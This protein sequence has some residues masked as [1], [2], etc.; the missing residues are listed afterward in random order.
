MESFDSYGFDAINNIIDLFIFSSIYTSL[1]CVDIIHIAIRTIN[2]TTIIP[3][4]IP[5][6]FQSDKGI[7]LSPKTK[8]ADADK[9]HPLRIRFLNFIFL[10]TVPNT[11][12]CFLFHQT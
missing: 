10:I 9:P 2:S 12:H 3:T 7:H 6:S 4:A 11:M 5:F 8:T 1:R